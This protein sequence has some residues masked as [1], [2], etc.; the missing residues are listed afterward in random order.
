MCR[1]TTPICATHSWWTRGKQ[2]IRCCKDD[3]LFLWPGGNQTEL[4]M[5]Y[6]ID[7]TKGSDAHS[8]M[9]SNDNSKG[10]THRTTAMK[11]SE[12]IF[13]FRFHFFLSRSSA[14]S[15]IVSR[16]KMGDCTII[17]RTSM[18]NEVIIICH[19]NDGDA[20]T[21]SRIDAMKEFNKDFF[22]NWKSGGFCVGP[23][24]TSPQD[25][26]ELRHFHSHFTRNY[27]W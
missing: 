20:I 21:I 23:M 12:E 14:R 9:T 16:G 24:F 27:R 17:I 8:Q 13:D 10:S 11:C 22:H 15:S 18:K 3:Y 6:L 19:I 4:S 1:I 5:C 25:A 7:T 2:E 26:I